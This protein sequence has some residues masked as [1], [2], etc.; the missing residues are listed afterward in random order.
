MVTRGRLHTDPERPAPRIIGSDRHAAPHLQYSIS[1]RISR[2]HRMGVESR[3]AAGTPVV[4]LPPAATR[5]QTT[6]RPITRVRYACGYR[7]STRGED[8]DDSGST[9]TAVR[10]RQRTG[11]RT[12]WLPPTFRARIDVMVSGSPPDVD[13]SVSVRS[14]GRCRSTRRRGAVDRSRWTSRRLRW[15]HRTAAT[16]G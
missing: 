15:A 12:A 9:L 7:G 10:E 3:A 4:V 14:A 8:H 1:A 11:G 6:A 16:S 2:L 13:Q 5:R